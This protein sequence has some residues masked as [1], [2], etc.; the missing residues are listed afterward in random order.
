MV[1]EEADLVAFRDRLLEER[2][3]EF[4]SGSLKMENRRG[5]EARTLSKL[6]P[7]YPLTHQGSPDGVSKLSKL[8]TFL[9]SCEVHHFFK[10][11]RMVPELLNWRV[12]RA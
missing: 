6:S 2:V 10:M 12:A 1:H 9:N 8:A 4:D 5:K 11:W 7:G 3:T